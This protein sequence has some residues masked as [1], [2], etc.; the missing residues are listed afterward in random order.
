MVELHDIWLRM[1]KSEDGYMEF[2]EFIGFVTY[3]LNGLIIQKSILFIL[4]EALG[5][6]EKSKMRWIHFKKIFE[7]SIKAH[8]NFTVTEVIEAKLKQLLDI[9]S[10]ADNFIQ[11]TIGSMKENVETDTEVQEIEKRF[12][13]I[14]V[15]RTSTIIQRKADSSSISIDIAKES[16]LMLCELF[17][18]V[19]C[20]KHRKHTNR[21]MSVS[22]IKGNDDSDY[23]LSRFSNSSKE[24]RT[25]I[26]QYLNAS[27]SDTIKSK[28][29]P[30]I[31]HL[32][33]RE[34][35]IINTNTLNLVPGS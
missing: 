15:Q 21:V 9:A 11:H 8:S 19:I 4:W 7:T 27:L 24:Q 23:D 25:Q 28:R 12:R 30:S 29:R 13:S 14:L 26:V 5:Y 6:N 16:K 33:D 31:Q 3:Y 2:D 32:K 20:C 22:D 1:D 10:N 18:S 35:F 34:S 17:G